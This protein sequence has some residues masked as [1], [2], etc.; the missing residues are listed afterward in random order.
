MSILKSNNN[1]IFGTGPLGLSVMDE[2]VARGRRVT[3]V[4]RSGQVNEPLPE[5]VTVVRGDATNPDSVADTCRGAD[6]VFH[7]A[8]PEYHEW[9]E[10]FPPITRG[11]VEGLAKLDDDGKGPRLVMGD[12]LYMYGPTRGKP[13]R[14]NL[15]YAATDRKGK[16]RAAMASYVLEAHQQ[17]RIMATIGRAADFY[18]PRVEGSAV[19]DI[20]FKPA[21][22]GKPAN[23]MGNPDQPHTYTYI[24]DFARGLV[25]LSDHEEAFGRAWHVAGA[26]TITTRQFAELVGREIGQ[27]VKLRVA[28]PLMMTVV[29]LFSP[30]AREMK[31]M[32]YEFAEP[33]VVDDSDYRAAF[34]NGVTP[35]EAAIRETVAWYRQHATQ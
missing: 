10:K 35:H 31:D 7:C 22:E 27:P 3:L 6:V 33:F 8:Q 32:M 21:L 2:L 4:N 11:I 24:R 30:G 5:G 25:T 26:P 17:G 18:G 14:E 34:G 1:V 29:G 16:T 20:F 28:G 12:N 19:G 15:P 9:P 13:I 23:V